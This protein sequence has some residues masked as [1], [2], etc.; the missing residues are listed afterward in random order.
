MLFESSESDVC[1][2]ADSCS[3]VVI[4]QATCAARDSACDK[5]E[6]RTVADVEPSDSTSAAKLAMNGVD[7]CEKSDLKGARHNQNLDAEEPD[8]ASK[9]SVLQEQVRRFLE[10]HTRIDVTDAIRQTVCSLTR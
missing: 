4:L 1:E 10:D 2:K 8:Q 6:F 3:P 5:G 7:A 9:L